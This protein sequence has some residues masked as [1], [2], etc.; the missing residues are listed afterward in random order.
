M[1]DF[2]HKKRPAA[3][4][5]DRKFTLGRQAFAKISA[6]EGIELTS[7]MVADFKSFDEMKLTPAERR[8]VL[9]RKYGKASANVV[10]KKPRL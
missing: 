3:T 7:D 1:V 10:R 5:S 2:T 6:V 9:A 8:T 4:N